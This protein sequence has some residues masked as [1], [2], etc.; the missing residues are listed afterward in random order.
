MDSTTRVLVIAPAGAATD[1][2]LRRVQAGACAVT[3]VAS[4]EAA[5]EAL[6]R[7]PRPE[8]VLIDLDLP[9]APGL[10]ALRALGRA[11]DQVAVLTFSTEA[12]DPRGDEAIAVGAQDHLGPESLSVPGLCRLLRRAVERQ[13]THRGLRGQVEALHAVLETIPEAVL[14]VASDGAVRLCNRAARALLDFA[15]G[16]EAVLGP[17]R[18]DAELLDRAARGENHDALPVPCGGPEPGQIRHFLATLRPLR[19]NDTEDGGLIVLRDVTAHRE[20]DAR[21]QALN[22][23]LAASLAERSEALRVAEEANRVKL[24]FLEAVSHELRTPL[25]PILGFSRLLL[26]RPAQP[27]A[28]EDQETIELISENAHRLLAVVDSM[29]DFQALQRRAQDVE[30]APTALASLLSALAASTREALADAPVHVITDIHADVPEIVLC[31]G[32]RLEQILQRLLK[33]AVAHTTQ[34]EIRV[35]VWWQP[36]RLTISVRDTG[37]GISPEHQA[38]IFYAFY[39]VDPGTGPAHGVGLGLPYAQVLAQSMG[40]S[41]QVQSQLG[42]GAEFIVELPAARVDDD[43]AEETIA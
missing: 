16:P 29:L 36:D 39:Q 4:L 35:R 5:R 34:G 38:R 20:V 9:E 27:L 26:R 1:A 32:R 37:V 28:A 43:D 25:T 41:I 13:R 7:R 11:V 10:G 40:G 22:A 3:H 15:A 12:D 30:T 8:A 21:I 2:V 14:G 6:D 42:R 17:L 33:N 19:F 31:D 24:K 23:E 18:A